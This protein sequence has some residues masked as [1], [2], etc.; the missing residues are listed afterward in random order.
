MTIGGGLD[1]AV[2]VEGKRST[3]GVSIVSLN[4]PFPR[5]VK[6]TGITQEIV[7][8]IARTGQLKL[9]VSG[10]GVGPLTV[11]EAVKGI[12]ALR[13]CEAEQLTDWGADAAQ[14][15]PGGKR[16]VFD[17]M[18][19]L[20]KSE[21]GA[22]WTAARGV[23]PQ[24]RLTV[25]PAGSIEGCALVQE[26]SAGLEEKLCKEYLGRL[27]AQPGRDANGQAVRSVVTHRLP[28]LLTVTR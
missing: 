25:S 15:A 1:G 7:D 5:G 18:K 22:L 9:W 24:V 4:G 10:R 2:E 8:G 28:R 12:A 11:P 19:A 13:K 14:F 21:I 17:Y 27:L 6:F 23:D 3:Y 20:R 26:G 16:A